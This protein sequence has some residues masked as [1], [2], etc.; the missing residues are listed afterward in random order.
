MNIDHRLGLGRTGFRAAGCS[1]AAGSA[2]R[3]RLGRPVPARLQSGRD[4]PWIRNDAD[5]VNLF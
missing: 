2:V 1:H 5:P 4:G 3:G